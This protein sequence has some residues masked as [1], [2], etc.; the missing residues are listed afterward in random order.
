MQSSAGLDEQQTHDIDND[1]SND[2]AFICDDKEDDE[3]SN[4]TIKRYLKLI[5]NT[6]GIARVFKHGAVMCVG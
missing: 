2:T 4:K 1:D 5:F 6:T 3:E